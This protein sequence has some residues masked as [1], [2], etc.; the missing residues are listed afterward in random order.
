LNAA[1]ELV[2][3]ASACGLALAALGAGRTL[4][5][6]FG[7]VP[8]PSLERRAFE[9]AFGVGVLGWLAFFL[10]VAGLF[11]TPWLI[12]LAALGVAGLLIRPPPATAHTEFAAPDRWVW[13]LLVILALLVALD[14]AEAF[15]PPADADSLA[16]HFELPRRY[17]EAGELFFLPRAVDGASPMLLHMT[18]VMALGMGGE[19][20]LTLWAG[21]LGWAP[22]LLLYVVAVRHIERRWAL[23]LAVILLSTPAVVYGGGAGQLETKLILFAVAASLCAAEALRTGGL[24]YAALAGAAAGC[25]LAAKYTGVFFVAVCGAPLLLQRRWLSHG[26]VFG[27]LALLAGGQWYVWNAVHSG[28]PMFPLLYKWLGATDEYWSAQAAAFLDYYASEAPAPSD[29]W[30]LVSYPF[31]A[32]LGG[33]EI[34]DAGRTGL[35]PYGLLILPF[36]LA[37]AWRARDRLRRHPLAVPVLI[38]ALYYAVWILTGTSQRVRHVLPIYPIFLIAATTA[39]VRFAEARRVA[40]PLAAAAALTILIQ[41]GGAAVYGLNYLRHLTAGETRE[42]FLARTVARYGPVPWINANLHQ[43]DRILITE[44]QIAYLIDVPTYGAFPRYQNLVNLR[45]GESD[46][47]RF[48]AEIRRLGITHVLMAPSLADYA[49]GVRHIWTNELGDYLLALQRAG[50][51]R[52]LYT[53]AMVAPVSRTVPTLGSGTVSS[54]VVAIDRDCLL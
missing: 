22:A 32:T 27:A 34:W 43:T 10:G 51:A 20:A 17:L 39:A 26:A 50:C 4:L 3:I 2:G 14:L 40:L 6:V 5:A 19:R 13:I 8:T 24:R 37:G 45:P 28:D 47:K 41:S 25:Y 7:A 36:A 38:A 46:S 35:G 52:V 12:G 48:F 44:R 15:S 9:F 54:D 16:Y 21:I 30:L 42:A 31:R 49:A 33:M 11:Q 18:Y 53:T 29:L 1:H 23:A